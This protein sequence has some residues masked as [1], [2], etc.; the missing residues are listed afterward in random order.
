MCFP[1]H[2]S[3]ALLLLR[4]SFLFFLILWLQ[5]HSS[6]HSQLSKLKPE[7]EEKTGLLATFELE[8]RFYFLLIFPSP[9]SNPSSPCFDYILCSRLDEWEKGSPSLSPKM[10][11]CGVNLRMVS[12]SYS[13]EHGFSGGFIL[14]ESQVVEEVSLLS[15]MK[16]F[17]IQTSFLQFLL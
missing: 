17:Q 14:P 9:G 7:P 1:C 12:V 10:G 13:S 5:S 11:F 16:R 6:L 3:R 15:P 4:N 2:S 8:R